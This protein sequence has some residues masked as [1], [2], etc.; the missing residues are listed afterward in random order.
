MSSKES[1]QSS[2]TSRDIQKEARKSSSSAVIDLSATPPDSKQKSKETEK[3]RRK[4]TASPMVV[5]AVAL[6]PFQG[7]GQVRPL[8]SH[9]GIQ[10]DTFEKS[11]ALAAA[12]KDALPSLIT[13]PSDDVIVEDVKRK[14]RTAKA[15]LPVRRV[16]H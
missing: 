5:S 6:S 14:L 12:S 15:P 1:P 4:G 11:F 3:A 9:H 10:F 16:L 7:S 8:P 2:K 13:F